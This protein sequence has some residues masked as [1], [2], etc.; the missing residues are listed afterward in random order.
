MHVALIHQPFRS[1]TA[2]AAREAADWLEQ[3]GISWELLSAFE[4]EDHDPEPFGL[5][6]IFGGDGSTLRTAR[7]AVT[8][9]QPGHDGTLPVVPVA[10]GTLSFLAELERTEVGEPLRP[11]LEGSYW[12]DERAMLSVEVAGTRSVALNDVVV[13]RGSELRAVSIDLAVHG[14][15]VTRFTA[16]GLVVSTATGSTAYALSAGGPVLAPDLRDI[17]LVPIAGH[18]S[19]LGSL[20]LPQ[21]AEI[22]LTIARSQPAIVSADG[23][24]DFA[25][26]PGQSVCV[27][28]A[29]ERAV[30][31]RRGDPRD[32][33]AHLTDRLRRRA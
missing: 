22:E 11:Y 3:R 4:L 20:V 26:Q 28:I 31:A 23:Q 6:V 17:V 32:F 18:L 27:R 33:Y 5:A 29:E 21:T 15:P 14:H 25:L 9:G 13:A 16:D 1:D 30:F 10:M 2:E 24:V 12:R 7:W 19:A 8:R